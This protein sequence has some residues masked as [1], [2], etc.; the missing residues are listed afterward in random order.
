MIPNLTPPTLAPEFQALN[1]STALA[2][3]NFAWDAVSNAISSG[4]SINLANLQDLANNPANLVEAINQALFRGEMDDDVR[5]DF[6][7]R[8]QR[9]HQSVGARA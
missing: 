8:R 9:L 4:I 3:A 2:R 5:V 7:H 6:D 1:A